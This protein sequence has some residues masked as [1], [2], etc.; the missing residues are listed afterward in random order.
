MKVYYKKYLKYKNK[1]I[2]LKKNVGGLSTIELEEDIKKLLL[3]K[4]DFP[5]IAFGSEYS[6]K[7]DWDNISE[8]EKKDIIINSWKCALEK[9]YKVFDFARAYDSYNYIDDFN[10]L[11]E[12]LEITDEIYIIAKNIDH[13]LFP[14]PNYKIIYT[15]HH[16]MPLVDEIKEIDNMIK[17]GKIFKYGIGNIYEKD[18]DK[19]QKLLN[20]C[21]E[22]N[23]EKPYLN[24]IEITVLSPQLNFIEFLISNNI[25]PVGYMALRQ[26]ETIEFNEEILKF[27]NDNK[28]TEHKAIL[29][30]LRS[31]KI[32]VIATS[33]KCDHI[34]ENLN[35]IDI[36][37]AKLSD[38]NKKYIDQS[39]SDM[40]M[41]AWN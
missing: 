17:Q 29:S 4:I 13:K 38:I 1:Y 22:N 3:D 14:L 7:L 6:S 25:I 15:R 8:E 36:K 9:G 40:F 16:G 34:E 21:T 28:I 39:W 32:T 23:L 19:L 41:G 5:T 33:T 26:P 18:K 37:D 12:E 31:R 20:Y 35:Y 10:K 24:E 30:Y 11:V 2:N 27:K